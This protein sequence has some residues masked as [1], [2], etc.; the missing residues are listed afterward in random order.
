MTTGAG[1]MGAPTFGQGLT[2][3][4]QAGVLGL[5]DDM[6]RKQKL[7][8]EKQARIEAGLLANQQFIDRTDYAH[9]LDKQDAQEAM[10]IKTGLLARSGAALKSQYNSMAANPKFQLPPLTPEMEA[11]LDAGDEETVGMVK[12]VVQKVQDNLFSTPKVTTGWNPVTGEMVQTDQQGN[13]INRGGAQP[14]VEQS[15]MPQQPAPQMPQQMGQPQGIPNEQMQAPPG[16]SSRGTQP[17]MPGIPMPLN[18]NPALQQKIGEENAKLQAE[19][20]KKQME[21]QAKQAELD[22]ALIEG[23]DKRSMAFKNSLD[24]LNTYGQAVNDYAQNPA[25]GDSIAPNVAYQA[26]AFLGN[27][28][29]VNTM[30]QS[31]GQMMVDQIKEL[32]ASGIAPTQM[33]NTEKEWERQ[34]SAKVGQG[35]GQDRVAAFNRLARAYKQD[36]MEFEEARKKAF[37]R[38][39]RE[40]APLVDFNSLPGKAAIKSKLPKGA[41]IGDIINGKYRVIGSNQVEEL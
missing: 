34:K 17:Q 41:K 12:N 24:N 3:G 7:E 9:N 23:E 2:R 36:M 21:E 26:S 16:W 27:N 19:V 25:L 30:E 20:L 32:K 15:Q 18:A 11:G 6:D 1:M 4:V 22:R 31:S 37:G 38:Q 29:A 39:G 13:I 14:Q 8:E 40:Y 5:T 10:D 35:S 33:M 28:P